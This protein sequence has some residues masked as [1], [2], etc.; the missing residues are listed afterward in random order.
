MALAVETGIGLAAAD[1]YVSLADYRAY[2]TARGWTLGADD[3]A[4]EVNLRRA[5]DGINRLWD[6]L[7]EAKTDDQAG[8]F[9]RT[10]WTGVPQR[11]K[12]AQ[13]ELAYLVQGGLDPFA[14][15]DSSSTGETIKVGPITIAG[16]SLPTGRPRIV[17]VEGLLRPYL[18][19]GPGQVRVM[20]G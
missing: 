2:G 4:D 13:C 9:P 6:Y 20:R 3:A 14:T 12:D 15:I 7:G 10:L 5:F 11:V 1:S 17:A 8:V 19:A 16:D 18:G